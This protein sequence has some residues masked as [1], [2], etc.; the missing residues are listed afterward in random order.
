M[1]RKKI[2]FIKQQHATRTGAKIKEA[3][4]NQQRETGGRIKQLEISLIDG[5][6]YKNIYFTIVFFF[7][8]LSF[9]F[10]LLI[11]GVIFF[12]VLF[13]SYHFSF[14]WLS[15]LIQ[16]LFLL[17]FFHSCC[18][19]LS[20]SMPY[21]IMK[22]KKK[23]LFLFYGVLKTFLC[24]IN[25]QL[26]SYFIHIIYFPTCSYSKIQINHISPYWFA[27]RFLQ[28]MH[29]LCRIICLDFNLCF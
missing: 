23:K 4:S 13:N 12:L 28:L 29:F 21:S 2:F 16:F 22:K 8:H 6:T 15:S 18:C 7:N 19:S 11:C 14:Y 27:D 25:L 3:E 20:S 10:A 17:F 5:S 24:N 9:I 1:F 26:Y